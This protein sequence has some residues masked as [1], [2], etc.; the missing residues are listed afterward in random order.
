MIPKPSESATHITY[1]YQGAVDRERI[2]R[3]ALEQQKRAAN[4]VNV[5]AVQADILKHDFETNRTLI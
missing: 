3:N 1:E 4:E 5:S 2:L